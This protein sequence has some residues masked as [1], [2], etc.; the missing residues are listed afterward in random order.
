MENNL[1]LSLRKSDSWK[2]FWK[3][4]RKQFIFES[5][6]GKLIIEKDYFVTPGARPPS[7]HPHP[8]AR[9]SLGKD[10]EKWYTR[11]RGRNSQLDRILLRTKGEWFYSSGAV[12]PGLAQSLALVRF[13][14]AH[15]RDLPLWINFPGPARLRTKVFLLARG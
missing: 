9:K 13:F 5:R 4:I 11:V 10:S 12:W 6:A 3:T 7:P 2:S 15:Q 8:R 1:Y 14:L